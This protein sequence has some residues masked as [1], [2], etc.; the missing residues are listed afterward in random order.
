MTAEAK[1]S[2]AS[3]LEK[4]TKSSR[5]DIPDAIETVQRHARLLE[6]ASRAFNATERKDPELLR[7][8]GVRARDAAED[9]WKI[10][11]HSPYEDEAA[12]TGGDTGAGLQR[13]LFT[14]PLLAV[15]S[16]AAAEDLSG[17]SFENV[18]GEPGSWCE[19]HA[20]DVAEDLLEWA[21]VREVP[22]NGG[23]MPEET[24]R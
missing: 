12:W 15:A 6:M 10:E 20:H 11:G 23:R 18:Y 3:R 7:L 22:Q 1:A 21:S 19:Y 24:D 13:A 2:T 5:L 9:L 14:L 16:E 8:I 4:P 17:D